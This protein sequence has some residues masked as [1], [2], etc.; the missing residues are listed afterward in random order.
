MLAECTVGCFMM[1][2]SLFISCRLLVGKDV[3]AWRSWV[4]CEN[5]PRDK[6][7]IQETVNQIPG[8]NI[9]VP[10]RR[11]YLVVAGSYYLRMR[12][13]AAWHSLVIRQ[14]TELLANQWKKQWFLWQSCRSLEPPPRTRWWTRPSPLV[15]QL[16]WLGWALDFRTLCG[17]SHRIVQ[18]WSSD[19]DGFGYSNVLKVDV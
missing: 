6:R 10:N 16:H 5:H 17:L 3:H 4:G 13:K 1:C 8:P 14:C 15:V 19:E 9:A 7:I 11:S 2:F 18:V 12:P